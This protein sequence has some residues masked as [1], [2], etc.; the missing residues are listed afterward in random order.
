MLTTSLAERSN[1]IS[2]VRENGGTY[3]GDL[4][5][6]ITH[7]IARTPTG[8]KYKFAKQW[9]VNLVSEEWLYQSVERGMILDEK[10]YH[11]ELPQERRGIDVKGEPAWRRER[12][13]T[14]LLKREREDSEEV[15]QRK[16]RR[17]LSSKLQS[18][19]ETIWGDIVGARSGSTMPIIDNGNAVP[20]PGSIP[21]STEGSSLRTLS[22]KSSAAAEDTKHAIPVPGGTF[23]RC[24]FYIHSFGSKRSELMRQHLVSHDAQVCASLDLLDMPHSG[25]SFV[26]VPHQVEIEELPMIPANVKVVNEWWVERCLEAKACLDPSAS[27]FD[28]PFAHLKVDGLESYAVSSTGFSG[29]ELLHLERVVKLMGGKYEEYFSRDSTVLICNMGQHNAQKLACA[30]KWSIAAVDVHWIVS[31]IKQGRVQAFGPKG[32]R[33]DRL[34]ERER[35]QMQVRRSFVAPPDDDAFA[36]ADGPVFGPKDITLEDDIRMQAEKTEKERAQAIER[37][38]TAFDGEDE[39]DDMETLQDILKAKRK[40]VKSDPPADAAPLQEDDDP[41]PQPADG[42][43]QEND[44]EARQITSARQQPTSD[45]ARPPISSAT[46]GGEADLKEAPEPESFAE[47]KPKISAETRATI[48]SLLTKPKSK[49]DLAPAP[50][51]RN[52][53]RILGRAQSN[54]STGNSVAGSPRDKAGNS[55]TRSLSGASVNGNTSINGRKL[56]KTNSIGSVVEQLLAEE[57]VSQAP[58]PTQTQRVMYVDEEAEKER[59]SVLDRMRGKTVDSSARKRGVERAITIGSLAGGRGTRTLKKRQNGGEDDVGG[60]N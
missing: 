10:L 55:F 7:L 40:E 57:E 30:E 2:Y 28:M 48:T 36:D 56:E 22:R 24:R 37:D 3:S 9:R 26:V 11:P 35:E 4:T 17:T 16:L 32:R 49:S 54:A 12:L 59:Q 5:K 15:G 41:I 51:T 19:N 60:S 42:G 8:N 13:R 43:N 1:I 53:R 18:Q 44:A 6:A 52:P 20:K 38:R 46:T 34:G 29:Y 23:S 45:A 47:P 58:E 39:D 21:N 14:T 31:C 25:R 50:I 33:L 27:K